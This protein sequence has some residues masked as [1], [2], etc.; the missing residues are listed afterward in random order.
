MSRLI[1]KL[2]AN[3]CLFISSNCRN[4]SCQCSLAHAHPK[5]G[6]DTP[7]SSEKGAKHGEV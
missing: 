4:N 1:Q 5:C 2:S 3:R 7:L 6:I